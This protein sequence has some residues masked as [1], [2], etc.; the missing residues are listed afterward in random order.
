MNALRR[1]AAGTAIAALAL[2]GSAATLAVTTAGPA[3]ASTGPTNVQGVQYCHSI[4]TLG[5]GNIMGPCVAYYESHN[6]D[7]AATGV[8]ECQNTLVPQGV[9]PNVG[10]CTSFLNNF[11][12]T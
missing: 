2:A 3:S 6:N 4:A 9:F 8:Y 11:K 7:T 1:R 12:G 5:S 10:T